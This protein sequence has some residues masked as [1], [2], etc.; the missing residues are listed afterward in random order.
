[1]KPFQEYHPSVLFLYFLSVIL[2]TMIQLHP[3]FLILSCLFSII[4]CWQMKLMNASYIKF[5]IIFYLII[6]LSN[7]IF[8]HYGA[9]IL[10]YVGYTAITL[11]ALVYGFI[12]AGLLLSILNW[13]KVMN[14]CL[15]SEKIIYLFG[16]RMPT[17]GLMISMILGMVPRFMQQFH[18]ISETQKA[19]GKDIYSGNYL[20]RIKNAFD[21]FL[22]LL[23]WAFESSLTLLNSME[24]RGYGQ[25]KRTHFHTY[26]FEQRDQY[27][28][29]IIVLLDLLFCFGYLTRFSSFYYYPVM[30]TI[31]FELL[32]ILYYGVYMM[33]LSLP[34]LLEKGGNKYVDI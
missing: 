9:T 12:F 20:L 24:A 3:C 30:K 25:K 6:A 33:L 21:I 5:L 32:D 1:M 29:I 17:I 16:K 26:K 15:D 27:V 10:F 23:T 22:I 18:K 14:V 2:T 11:E 13:F 4:A 8:V 7:P 34:I 19:L 31:S 28:F